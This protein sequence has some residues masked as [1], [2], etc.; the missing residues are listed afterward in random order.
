MIHRFYK[1]H[2]KLIQ[3]EGYI[4][5]CKELSFKL[6]GVLGQDL[7]EVES[8]KQWVQI[9]NQ[10]S[11]LNNPGCKI[12]FNSIF[13]HG[14]NHS[15]M[16]AYP[17]GVEFDYINNMTEKRELADLILVTSFYENN[18]KI[19]EKITFNQAKWGKRQKTTSSWKIDNGQLFLLAN[20]PR[21]SGVNGSLIP[22]TDF[23]I[24]DFS[25]GLGS[26]GL[27]TSENFIYLSARNLQ[28]LIGGKKSINL[29]DF[30][31]IPINNTFP[32]H[33][34]FYNYAPYY[35]SKPF[36]NSTYE[37]IT[38]YLSGRIGEVIINNGFQNDNAKNLFHNI[39]SSIGNLINN[40]STSQG[41]SDFLTNYGELDRN[42]NLINPEYQYL[43]NLGIVQM[44][45]KLDNETN[46]E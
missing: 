29:N 27:M 28:Q 40:E 36:C 38:D 8:V 18:K 1:K 3:T 4:K 15:E 13:I 34:V 22:N 43:G 14:F 6:N 32:H 23:N 17:S 2:L 41:L 21:F 5:L 44:N 46:I 24:E 37:F 42:D 19:L 26:Y 10:T 9:F 7:N 30:K 12:N 33:H 16:G 45:I 25:N 20:F 39:L 35:F 11:S 31:N